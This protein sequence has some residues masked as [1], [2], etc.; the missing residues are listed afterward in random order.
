MAAPAVRLRDVCVDFGG[1]VVIDHID[2][3]VPAGRIV[4]IIGPS[5]CGKTTLVRLMTGLLAPTSGEVQLLGR[6]PRTYAASRTRIGY[7]P[8]HPA[9]YPDL[10]IR[11]NL[12]F[13]ESLQGLPLRHRR[14]REQALLAWVGL[15]GQERKKVRECSGG[16]QR[17]V[18]LAAAL[19]HDP[20]VVFLDEPT[21]GIDPILRAAIW[22]RLGEL[23]DSG[24]TMIVTTQVV[25]EAVNCDLVVVLSEGRCVA[26]DT[27]EELRRRATGGEPVVVELE[28]PPTEA[29]REALWSIEGV[30][31]VE[32]EGRRLARL[33]V[34]DAAAV[35]PVVLSTAADHGDPV[36]R[37][38]S[39]PL[40]YDEVFARIVREHGAGTEL[41]LA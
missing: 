3:N 19:L 34:D 7:L 16:M 4:G 38:E 30:H 8:Q 33:L 2:L 12:R 39:T 29:F 41:E 10:S 25:T 20:D 27:P 31:N 24:K 35:L 11:S 1:T 22:E 14:E 9:L 36:A 40:D 28:R 37:A 18:A 32:W 15:D 23:R 17:R 13:F 26:I 6:D 5:G 21:A